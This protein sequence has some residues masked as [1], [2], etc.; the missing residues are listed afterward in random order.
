MASQHIERKT[1]YFSTQ[2]NCEDALRELADDYNRLADRI[3]KSWEENARLVEQLETVQ[4]ECDYQTNRAA[5]FSSAVG[6]ARLQLPDD[7]VGRGVLDRSAK[8]AEE[9]MFRFLREA[10]ARTASSPATKQE[11][12]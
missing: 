2:K 6:V 4:R 10:E 11:A 9:L 5:I 8:E 1:L 12:E 7:I 3:E